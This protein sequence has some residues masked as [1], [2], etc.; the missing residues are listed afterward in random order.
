MAIHTTVYYADGRHLRITVD[1]GHR[2][3]Q[4]YRVER[5]LVLV[6]TFDSLAQLESWL[7]EQGISLADLV[8]D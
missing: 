7:R 3:S 2:H 6:G 8:E 4:K 5:D 1:A